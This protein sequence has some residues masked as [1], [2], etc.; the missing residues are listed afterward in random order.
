[1]PCPTIPYL[2]HTNCKAIHVNVA[3]N[4]K[5]IHWPNRTFD[6]NYTIYKLIDFSGVNEK[7]IMMCKIRMLHL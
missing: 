6:Q 7:Q 2:F 4:E 3:I 5:V 1:M